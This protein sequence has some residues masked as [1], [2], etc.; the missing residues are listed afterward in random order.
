[1]LTMHNVP[2]YWPRLSKALNRPDWEEDARFTTIASLLKNGSIIVTE[3]EEIF[4]SQD[5]SYWA[6]K[7]DDNECIWAPAASLDEVAADPVLRDQ[8]AFQ[9]LLDSEG[10]PYEVV[11]TPF[12]ID[13]VDIRAR[14]RAPLVGENNSFTLGSIDIIPE[15][16]P[17]EKPIKLILSFL[18]KSC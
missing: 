8:G 18:T 14:K 17:Q 13:G 12:M 5:L 1:M 4:R 10:S 2:K 9:T 15:V 7:L 16:A 3:I 11:S 6:K